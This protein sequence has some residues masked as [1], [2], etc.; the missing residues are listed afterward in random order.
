MCL[1]SAAKAIINFNIWRLPCCSKLPKKSAH[2]FCPPK[3]VQNV[4]HFMQIMA[5]W[6]M[7]MELLLHGAYGDEGTLCKTS[8]LVLPVAVIEC[9][10]RLTIHSLHPGIPQKGRRKD[11]KAEFSPSLANTF[12]PVYN[13]DPDI[14]MT[15]KKP[16]TSFCHKINE[17]NTNK[18]KE[19]PYVGS[20]SNCLPPLPAPRVA[21]PILIP[22]LNT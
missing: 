17:V 21:C 12:R 22:S 10:M 13:P 8:A 16:R 11:K 1:T 5:V 7:W 19:F 20:E 2:P 9:S 15:R 14:M 6:K 4:S 3:C 18:R